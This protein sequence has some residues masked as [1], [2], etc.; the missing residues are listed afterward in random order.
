LLFI[1]SMKNF[2][3]YFIRWISSKLSVPFWV[4]GHAHLTMNVYYDIHEIII[5]LGLN[6]IVSVGFWLEWLEHKK[7]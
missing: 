5:S 6:I 1:N 2:F 7:I 3:V 4:V